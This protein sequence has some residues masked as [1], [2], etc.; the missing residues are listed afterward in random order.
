MKSNCEHSWA[1]QVIFPSTFLDGWYCLKCG[2]TR[3]HLKWGGK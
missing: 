2:E 1:R 3:K